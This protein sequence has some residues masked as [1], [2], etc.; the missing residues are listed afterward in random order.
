MKTVKKRR[1]EW[2]TDY[3]ARF[4]LLKAKKERLVFRKTNRYIIGQIIKSEIA[5]DKTLFYVTSKILL[6]KGWP[7]DKKGSLK[8]L[9]ASYLV[10]YLTGKEALKKGIKE[11]I[12]DIGM[13]R[14]VHKSRIY[15]FLKGAI[16]SGVKIKYDEE[17][18]P[19]EEYF[20]K[21]EKLNE[22]MEKI[23]KKF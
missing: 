8:S 15:A 6:D 7:E 18:I 10:G 21:N 1:H 19:N 12:F 2:K 16:D 13:Y 3:K 17:T 22:I 5:K 14:N 23:K 4:G 20:K 11:A 9:H